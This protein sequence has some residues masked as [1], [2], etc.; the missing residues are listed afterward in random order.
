M[1]L[2]HRFQIAAGIA[3]LFV[4]FYTAYITKEFIYTVILSGL[5]AY[6]LNPIFKRLVG[7]TNRKGISS[8]LSIVA[9]FIIL[10]AVTLS[11]ISMLYAEITRLLTS[12][13]A[14]IVILSISSAADNATKEYVLIPMSSAMNNY[15]PGSGKALPASLSNYLQQMGQVFL[16]A[17]SWILPMIQSAIAAT[18][19]NLPILFAQFMVAIFFT[20]YLLI[21]G[22]SQVYKVISEFSEKDVVFKFLDEL[23]VVYNSLFNVYFVTSMLS[24]VFACIGF[25]LMGLPYPVLTGAV[26]GIFTL[27]PLVGPATVYIPLTIYYLLIGDY[28]KAVEI[29]VFGTIVLV[30][31]PENV[32]RPHMAMKEASIHPIITLLAYSAPVFVIGIMGVIIGPALYGF[33]LAVYRTFVRFKRE[34][35]TAAATASPEV[36]TGKIAEIGPIS[37]SLPG[38]K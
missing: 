6:M 3:L 20:Y 22:K 9:V 8:F 29:F 26:V 34:N 7:L 37:A 1:E 36:A 4:A 5:M 14:R 13:S 18:I 38:A 11:T 15:S 33:L 12:D 25:W 21:D 24:G 35:A 17:L 30:I 19:S 23:N 28:F 31:V 32:L 2:S 27:I 16:T 10:M